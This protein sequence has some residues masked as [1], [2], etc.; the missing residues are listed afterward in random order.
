MSVKDSKILK[1]L[2]Y[3]RETKITNKMNT[4]ERIEVGIEAKDQ[5]IVTIEPHLAAEKKSISVGL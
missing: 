4:I 5:R 2:F 1:S 3:K